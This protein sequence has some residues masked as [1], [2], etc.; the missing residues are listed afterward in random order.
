MAEIV[1]QDRDLP[2]WICAS[3]SVGMTNLF[4]K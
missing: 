2:V 1:N 4:R 3:T